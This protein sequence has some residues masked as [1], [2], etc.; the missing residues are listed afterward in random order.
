MICDKAWRGGMVDLDIRWRQRFQNFERAFLLLE[1]YI[2]K[3][4]LSEIERAGLIQFFEMTLE[5]SWKLMKDFLESESFV[6]NSPRETVKQAFQI[7]L[8]ENGHSWIDALT[9]RN[10]ATH[11]Y[12][13]EVAIKLVESIHTTYFEELRKFYNRMLKEFENVRA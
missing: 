7:G 5:L 9:D 4:D 12:N 8:I 13:E 10:L 6:V 3:S 11:T 2:G 1:K